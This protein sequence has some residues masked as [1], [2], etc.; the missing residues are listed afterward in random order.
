LGEA[1]A[2]HALVF[3]GLVS[4]ATMLPLALLV[5]KV[6][7][8]E[9]TLH[10]LSPLVTICGLPALAVGLLFWRRMAD[11]RLAGLQTVGIGVGVL[12]A[13]VMGVA[14]VLA[15]PEPAMLL[16]TAL[17]T[18]AA[19]IVVALWFE[20]PVAQLPAGAALAAAWLIGFYLLRGDIAWTL[21]DSALMQRTLVSALSGHVLVPLAGIFAGIA[22][23]FTRFTRRDDALQVA[24]VAAAT[25]ALSLALVLW[26]GFGRAG[27]PQNATWTL[28]IYAL[29]ALAAAVVLNRA[30][31]AQA[32]SALLLGALAQ[33]IVYRYRAEWQLEQPLVVALL[34]HASL[35]AAAGGALRWFSVRRANAADGRRSFEKPFVALAW[36][37]LV[38]SLAAPAGIVI[39]AH[40]TTAGSLAA[41][42]AW[43][44]AVWLCLAF[45]VGWR[46]LV[47]AS[48][49]A[50]VFAVLCGVTAGVESRAWYGAVPR[51]WLDPWF[52]EAQGIALAVYCLVVHT[53]RSWFRG[54]AKPQAVWMHVDHVVLMGLVALVVLLATYA[55]V[56]GVAQ[57]L[58]P[59]E[60]PRGAG[61]AVR[62]VP[63][64]ER[65]QI[66]GIANAHAAGRGAWALLAAVAVALAA[67]LRNCRAPWRQSGLMFLGAS[68]CPLI[69]ALW[70]PEIAVASALRW[71]SA[72]LFAFVSGAIWLRGRTEP[73][74]RDL[75]V[76]LLLLIYSWMGAYV[77]LQALM[78]AGMM[79]ATAS[80][81]SYALLWAL[82]AG[83]A[84]LVFPRLTSARTAGR[85]SFRAEQCVLVL[86][87]IAPL[88]VVATFGVA[89]ALDQHPI[90]GPE[91]GSW[92]RRIGWDV[93]YGVPLSAIALTLLGYAIRDR[94]SQFAFVA[95]LLFNVVATI[96]VLMRLARGGGSLDA[97]AWITVAQANAIVAGGVALAWLAAHVGEFLRNSQTAVSEKLLYVGETRLR[98]PLLLTAQAVLAAALC[99]TFL[100]PAAARVAVEPAAFGWAVAA[101]GPL[102]WS[103]VAM[104]AIAAT[105]LGWRRGASVNAVA[106]FMAALVALVALTAAHWD[107]GNWL[108]FHTLLAGACLAAWVSPPVGRAVAGTIREPIRWSEPAARFFGAMAVI[109]A[110]RAYGADPASPWWTIAALTTIGA[111]NLW[112]AWHE[113][114]GGFVW[115]AALLVLPAASVLWLDWV[116][117]FSSTQGLG[118]LTEFLWFN[119]PAAAAL[120][121]VSVLI[122]RRS[123]A[124]KPAGPLNSETAATTARKPIS[125]VPFHRFAAWAAVATLL[126]TTGVGLFADL[127]GRPFAASSSLAWAAWGATALAALA[128]WWDSGIRWAIACLYSI[129]LIAVGIFLDGLNFQGLLFQWALALAL[130]AYS[131]ATSLLWSARDRLSAM[132]MKV[133][134]PRA[135]TSGH[136]WLVSANILLGVGMLLLVWWIEQALPQF[137]QRMVAAYAVAAQAFAIGLLA[138]GTVRTPLQYLALVWG[139]LFAVAFAWAWIPPDFRAPWLHRL[140]V[141][142][143]SIVAIVVIYG[144]GL[145]KF[146]RRENEWTRAAAR[147]VPP[148]S[149]IAVALTLF[150][151]VVEVRQFLATGGVPIVTS[152]IVAI[153]A[154]LAGLTIA[155]LVAA[156]VPGRDPLGLSERGRTGYVYA[157]E[158]LGA[159]LFVHIRVTMPWLFQGWFVRFWPL[160]AMGIAFVGVGFGE[161]FERRR[162]RVLAEPLHNTGAL[163][164][165]LPAVGFWFVSSQVHYSLLLLSIGMLYAALSV[166]RGWWLYAVL[167]AIAA[168]GSLWY[169]LYSR[170]GLGFF[171]HPQLWLIPPA[172]AA[173]VA[174]YIN[175]ERLTTQQL[176][177]L[178]YAAAIVIYVSSTADVF[179]NG[180]ADAPWLP[181]VLAGLSILGV[182]AG[183]LLRV[184]AFLYL[185]TAF[186]VVALMTIIWH[187]AIHQQRTWILWIAGIVTGVLIIA[188]FGLFEKRRDDVL[189][190]VEQLKHWEA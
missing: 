57:E 53:M 36:S 139:V 141:S 122:H 157:A 43:L 173:L 186:L 86:L 114:R 72:G 108:A 14:V 38:T 6:P 149:A 97:V 168:N 96:V 56:P 105:W 121:I 165:L 123:F 177:A 155:A 5:Y 143:A 171:E 74:A 66:A 163:L 87:A 127:E 37:A 75:M 46:L 69:A 176:A 23:C 32:G 120:A 50:A 92:F 129:G 151:L 109:L 98:G 40:A 101:N 94:S 117:Q 16:P 33:A 118:E 68:L 164:P 131:L 134:V 112:I 41:S 83:G 28:A 52:L 185:G 27:D 104:A 85:R 180:V 18:A 133:G 140:V 13:L 79:I 3:L 29:A 99:A 58:A 11:R 4:A 12:G 65:F 102:G 110:V 160:V 132:A 67:G 126:I 172:L 181:A 111:R 135:A 153:G 166:L 89:R 84:A 76:G 45:L 106:V 7:P 47:T 51:P 81:W 130:A 146:L 142:V 100:V 26:F 152:A 77:A 10:R 42:S 188:L 116:K 22:W 159:L 55:V 190:V 93:S 19:M 145:V 15:W 54:G 44:A 115:V 154:A 31:A 25:A 48:Q 30:D 113:R 17:A 2:R 183:I 64:I 78:R 103:A 158:A 124:D 107:N 169:W 60:A 8:I 9:V 150:V 91:P 184:R 1:A 147:L 62:V 156:L 138:R 189:R 82:L 144:F 90:V 20:I 137:T 170:E 174:G 187:A 49:L 34:A 24:L 178:R 59:L 175:R 179:I 95:G 21:G 71:L 162:Q 80:V 148:L 39:T 119:V 70:E 125:R 182:F 73:L 136:G 88:A 161:L 128:C 167:A 63:P 35:M 61:P